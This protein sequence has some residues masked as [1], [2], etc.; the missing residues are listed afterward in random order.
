ML[1]PSATLVPL[2]GSGDYQLFTQWQKEK[3]QAEQ[4]RDIGNSATRLFLSL[5]QERAL[6]E[7]A[8]A[9]TSTAARERLAKQ[10][11]AT[12]RAVNAFRPLATW[13]TT[14]WATAD[15]RHGLAGAIQDTEHGLDSLA[16]QR[17][18]ADAGPS[19]SQE[20]FLYYS[21][22]LES[23]LG[24]FEELGQ[25]S[26]AGVSE[27]RQTLADLLAVVDMTGREDAILARGWKTGHLSSEEHR[28]VLDAV[29]TGTYLLRAR[30]AP[31]LP[32]DETDLYRTMTTSRSWQIRAALEKQLAVTGT[33]ADA[34]QLK[35]PQRAADWRSS[36]DVIT[37]Q[38]LRLVQRQSDNADRAATR[39]V[40]E[41]L[42]VFIAVSAVGLVAMALIV[43]TSWRLTALFRRRI[44]ELRLAAQ[45][46]QH[47]LPDTVARL[48]RGE[49]IDV[50]A[51]VRPV[52]PTPDELGDLGQALNLAMQSAVSAAVRQAEQ[53][54]GFERLLQRVARRTQILIGLQMKRLDE[55][56]RKHEED[57]AVLN[58]LFDLD[59]LTARLR[60]YEESLVILAGGQ[61]HRRWRK[62]ARLLDVL[63]AA[64]G[65]VQDYRRISIDIQDEAWVAEGVV[66]PLVHILAE[67]MENASAFSKPPT[68]VEVRAAAVTQG[69]VVEIE[70]RGLGM[71]P[72][73]YTAA[74]ALMESPPQ[75]DVMTHA[76]DVRLGLYVVARLA[77]DQGIRVELRPSA[78]GGTRVIVL[79][80]KSLVADR[81]GVREGPTGLRPSLRDAGLLA[82]PQNGEVA[83]STGGSQERPAHR[84]ARADRIVPPAASSD[85]GVD[86]AFSL[87]PLPRRLRQAGPGTEPEEPAGAAEQANRRPMTEHDRINRSSATIGAF[88]RAS[89]RARTTTDVPR[90]QSTESVEPAAPMTEDPK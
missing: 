75:L 79:L 74:N 60:R 57:P 76:D 13:N 50:E 46:L 47:R 81:S 29:S 12:D 18:A 42:A 65:E 37:S 62:P 17:S 70:D 7:E 10:R 78:F 1:V 25:G 26:R 45:E 30:V 40:Q 52:P 88:Q 54:R 34:G 39:S 58:G 43:V 51:E 66:G 80:P 36:A 2:L 56:E 41:L 73:Q 19:D 33:R 21:D 67:L 31:S 83:R 14:V 27:L 16:R 28:L 23:V 44:L 87:R 89:R 59:H 8:R 90:T 48:E 15:A 5:E 71:D 22:L 63:R 38:L 4:A 85:T 72:D 86:S 77:A 6:T 49:D 82:R 69:V 32:S 84:T 35:L 24:V 68:P 3:R 53:H 11:A 20:S 64:Q 9:D 61:T 55:L